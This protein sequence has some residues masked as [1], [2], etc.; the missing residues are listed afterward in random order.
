M[1]V[2]GLVLAGIIAVGLWFYST[3]NLAKN[4]GGLWPVKRDRRFEVQRIVLI[5]IVSV[6]L[7]AFAQAAARAIL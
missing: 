6:I 7:A 4:A 3:N 1:N 2:H 5:L